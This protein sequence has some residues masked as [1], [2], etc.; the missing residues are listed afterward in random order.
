MPSKPKTRSKPAVA[1]RSTAVTHSIDARP[2]LP[3]VG[4]VVTFLIAGLTK[5]VDWRVGWEGISLLVGFAVVL[6]CLQYIPRRSV[7]WRTKP[8]STE[9][10]LK[11]TIATMRVV[12][13]AIMLFFIVSILATSDQLLESLPSSVE[14]L[15]KEP[16]VQT[17]NGGVASVALEPET[18]NNVLLFVPMQVTVP[19]VVKFQL[20]NLQS[21][22]STG[23]SE[24]KRE[25]L[26]GQ[27]YILQTKEFV[28]DVLKKDVRPKF[29]VLALSALVLSS[30]F[31]FVIFLMEAF[32]DLLI[33]NAPKKKS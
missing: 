33:R 18:K 24:D 2:K 8:K 12:V 27:L 10:T 28:Q 22:R 29:H 9:A 7:S 14:T 5:L 32:G 11:Q 4:P 30:M 19:A 13:S 16:K 26:F 20:P 15:L 3:F 31:V 6:F 23:L 17:F 25:K 21:T 1:L